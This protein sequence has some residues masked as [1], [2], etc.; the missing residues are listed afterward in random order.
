MLR[1]GLRRVRL[2]PTRLRAAGK[3][4]RA[5]RSCTGGDAPVLRANAVVP[6]A[7]KTLWCLAARPSSRAPT[8][9]PRPGRPPCRPPRRPEPRPSSR[10]RRCA[11]ANSRRAPETQ[12]STGH[13]RPGSPALRRTSCGTSAC[14]GADRHHPSPANRRELTNTY[15]SFRPRRPPTV[16]RRR[17]RPLSAPP[18]APALAASA[19]PGRASYS[20]WRRATARPRRRRGREAPPAVDRRAAVGISGNWRDRTA[21]SDPVGFRAPRGTPSAPLAQRG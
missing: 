5:L 8:P 10:R 13:R 17:R 6:S 19:C 4:G 2:A 18:S 16:P 20:A 15:G 7:E 3:R 1:P 21:R 11:A 14:R 9:G 12:G